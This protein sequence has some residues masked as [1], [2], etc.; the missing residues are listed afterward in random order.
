MPKLLFSKPFALA[1]R[2][3][4]VRVGGP[5]TWCDDENSTHLGLTGGE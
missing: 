2:P 1:I 4:F 5:P 3:S